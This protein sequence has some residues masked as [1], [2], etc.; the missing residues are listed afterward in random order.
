MRIA[1]KD[2]WRILQ[3]FRYTL[4]PATMLE[5]YTTHKLLDTLI[6]LVISSSSKHQMRTEH[7]ANF[8]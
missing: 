3:V 4:L 6:V 5:V 8:S 7:N 1:V 2:T